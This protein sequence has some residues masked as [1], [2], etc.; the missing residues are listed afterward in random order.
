M[1]FRVLL[2]SQL[3]LDNTESML[4]TLYTFL[5]YGIPYIYVK[6]ILF[7]PRVMWAKN[8]WRMEKKMETT[9]LGLGF[10][11]ALLPGDPNY[12]RV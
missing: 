5:V 1:L 2:A 6:R 7:L 3:Y 10:R 9:I 11:L 8:I 4:G 12:P